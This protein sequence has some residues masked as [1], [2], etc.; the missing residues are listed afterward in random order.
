MFIVARNLPV[1]VS[2]VTFRNGAPFPPNQDTAAKSARAIPG[3][4]KA[5]KK[6]EAKVEAAEVERLEAEAEHLELTNAIAVIEVQEASARREATTK[7]RERGALQQQ[8][9]ILGRKEKSAE[10][11]TAKVVDII[12]IQ[13]SQL[14]VL[15]AEVGGFEGTISELRKRA[16]KVEGEI[17]VAEEAVEVANRGYEAAL[18]KLNVMTAQEMELEERE[19]TLHREME[20]RR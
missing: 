19:G 17:K 10:E 3:V 4:L 9:Q 11:R 2:T 8:Q 7:E 18:M 6:T 20:K 12:G 15:V 13:A 16:K 1:P 5:I 14:S